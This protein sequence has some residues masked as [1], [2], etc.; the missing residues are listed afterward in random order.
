MLSTLLRAFHLNDKEIIVFQ[1]VLDLGSQPASSI[2]RMCEFPRNTVRG[3]LDNLVRRGLL[4]RTSRAHTQYYAVEQKE[5]IKRLLIHQRESND[6]EINRQLTLLEQYGDELQGRHTARSR[7]KVTFYEG[8]KGLEYVYEDTLTSKHGLRSWGSF[9]ANQQ[10]LPAYFDTYYKRRAKKG[11]PMKSI[12]PDTPLS[13]SHQKNDAQELRQ[14]A[15]VPKEI[16]NFTP[17]LQVYENKVNIV[18]WKEKIGIIIESKEIADAMRVIFDLS[19]EAAKAYGK[20]G[21]ITD[22]EERTKPQP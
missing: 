11:I 21:G 17:E 1:K 14:S 13:R 10:S 6:A 5:N 7:P 8:V 2:A 18:S 3:I 22:Y 4:V 16:L 20:H 12:H 15:L 19:F 9:D